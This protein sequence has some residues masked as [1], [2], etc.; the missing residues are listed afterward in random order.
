MLRTRKRRSSPVDFRKRGTPEATGWHSYSIRIGYHYYS[1]RRLES[2][3]LAFGLVW[4]AMH[5]MKM[6]DSPEV[7]QSKTD[8]AVA[9]IIRN[10]QD[11]AFLTT[12]SSALWLECA[13]G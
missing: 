4:D 6:D 12:I 3:G 1:Y 5:G 11:V 9:H 13:N 10:H 2:V 7:T 8:T